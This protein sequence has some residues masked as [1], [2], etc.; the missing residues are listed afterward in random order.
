VK[1]LAENIITAQLQIVALGQSDD[2]QSRYISSA[3]RALDKKGVQYQVTPMG[4]DI[5]AE[6]IDEIFDAYKAAHTA[7][8]DMG[9]NRILTH[10]TIDHRLKGCKGLDE[11]VR[12]VQSKL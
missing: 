12:S 1:I 3:V 5:E 10:V 4:T 8:M 2:S 11:K 6:S 9:V 7:V